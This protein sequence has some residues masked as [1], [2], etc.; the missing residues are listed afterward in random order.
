MICKAESKVLSVLNFD[1]SVPICLHF[2]RRY[3]KASHSDGKMHNFSK[4]LLEAFVREPQSLK[5][6]PSLIAASAVYISRRNEKLEPAWN[7]TLEYNTSFKETDLRT[8]V[9]EMKSIVSKM[10]M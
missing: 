10:K 8:C 4:S 6:L 2:L 9:E 1:V 5:Y 7:G 3:S